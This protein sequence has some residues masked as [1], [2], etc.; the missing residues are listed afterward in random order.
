MKQVI[1]S[2]LQYEYLGQSAYFVEQRNCRRL[3]EQKH[4]RLVELMPAVQ[5]LLVIF[6]SDLQKKWLN[7]LIH[8]PG[9]FLLSS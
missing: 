7:S 6:V 1:V 8:L 3:V 2:G 9:D 5:E 4:V